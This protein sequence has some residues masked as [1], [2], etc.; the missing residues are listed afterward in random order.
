MLKFLDAIQVSVYRANNGI[1]INIYKYIY[2][3]YV[4]RELKRERENRGALQA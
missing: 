3:I 1:I 4:K 2:N